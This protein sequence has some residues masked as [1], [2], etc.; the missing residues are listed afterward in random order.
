MFGRGDEQDGEGGEIGKGAEGGE[1]CSDVEGRDGG[2]E[3]E[4]AWGTLFGD[5]EGEGG[6]L[7]GEDVV[8][9]AS[10]EEAFEGSD[11]RGVVIEDEEEEGS[12]GGFSVEGE[13]CVE[14]FG[15]RGE[16]VGWRFGEGDGE[17]GSDVLL[18]FDGDGSVHGLDEA[19]CEGE[20]DA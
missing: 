5:A 3:D 16:D 4:Q 6:L 2:V 12:G 8:G 9:G 18:A 10:G 11:A 19:F 14:W 15:G 7:G 13:A 20:A 1:E 17:G